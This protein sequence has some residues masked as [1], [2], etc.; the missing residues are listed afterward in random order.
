[1]SGFLSTTLTRTISSRQ[2]W[3]ERF[4][5]ERRIICDTSWLDYY[6]ERF[7]KDGV[8]SILEIGC[9]DGDCAL[10]LRRAGFSICATD[11]SDEVVR[12][13]SEK[14]PT[15]GFTVSRLDIRH[16]FPFCESAF[17]VVLSNLSAHYFSLRKTSAVFHEVGRVLR[18]G[19]YFLLRVNDSREYLINKAPDTFMRLPGGLVLSRNGKRKQYFTDDEL[20]GCL[21]DFVIERMRGVEFPCDGHTKYALEVLARRPDGCSRV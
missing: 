15:D 7:R 6:I 18:P 13:L 14:G 21:S 17:D 8:E 1:M 5:S 20:K 11:I 16:R 3:N 9:G 10:R 4:S 2:I 19:G 12:K